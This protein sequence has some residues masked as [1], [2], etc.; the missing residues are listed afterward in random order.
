MR[1]ADIRKW[2]VERLSK[3]VLYGMIIVTA[4]VYAA[5]WLIGYTR[6]DEQNPTFNAPLMTNVLLVFPGLLVIAALAVV[7]WAVLT[8]VRQRGDKEKVVNGVPARR[9]ALTVGGAT[10]ALLLVTF[11]LGSSSPVVINGKPYE[12]TLWLKGADM[13]VVTSLL[14]IVVAVGAVLWGRVKMKD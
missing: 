7:A 11:L 13:F 8:G 4:L 10:A 9:L 6:P 3:A 5:F 1:I 2:P 14:M 12:E